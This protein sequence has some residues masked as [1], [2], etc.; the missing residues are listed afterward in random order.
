MRSPCWT[1]DLRST[2]A[3]LSNSPLIIQ[4]R[5]WSFILYRNAPA[6]LLCLDEWSPFAAP[7]S[8]TLR[9]AL[10][11][12]KVLMGRRGRRYFHS[13]PLPLADCDR[14]CNQAS[15]C[16]HSALPRLIVTACRT[17]EQVLLI[18]TLPHHDTPFTRQSLLYLLNEAIF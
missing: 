12:T 2:S 4:A 16:P 9:H 7:L 13:V 17:Y 6:L 10:S 15:I 18:S 14:D 1:L 11:R 3:L 8:A 5:M